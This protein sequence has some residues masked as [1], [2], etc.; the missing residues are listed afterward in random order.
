VI[1]LVVATSNP[2]K[3]REIAEILAGLPIEVLSLSDYPAIPEV[4]ESGSTFEENALIKALHAAQYTGEA[5]LA[6]DSGLE[7]DALD[8]KPG[9]H[10]SRFAGPGATDAQK[11]ELLLQMLADVPD[12]KRTARFRCVAALVAPSGDYWTF[13]GACEGRIIHESRGSNGFGYDPLFYVPDY[14]MTMA[15][16]P[17][18]V[19]NRISHRAKAMAEARVAIGDLSFSCESGCDG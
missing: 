2:G 12:D 7:V 19:K 5:V 11:N 1:R 14:D 18:E 17:A 15:E 13:D 4:E 6:D 8:G 10:S 3:A 9:I 16:L